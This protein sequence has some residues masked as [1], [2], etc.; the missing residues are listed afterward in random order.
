MFCY[1]IVAGYLVLRRERVVVLI[2]C[3]IY[4][5][6]MRRDFDVVRMLSFDLYCYC[7]IGFTL[8]LKIYKT[9]ALITFILGKIYSHVECYG[10]ICII[11]KSHVYA[12]LLNFIFKLILVLILHKDKIFL[13]YKPRPHYRS[14]TSLC[15]SRSLSRLESILLELVLNTRRLRISIS[16][17][18]HEKF[19]FKSIL[20]CDI[21]EFLLHLF[22]FHPTVRA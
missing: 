7:G 19:H 15:L 5:I 10:L 16:K 4:I 21:I 9:L 20:F 3:Q 18:S 11:T 14:E 6:M 13:R 12:N 22:R 1:D 17:L 2:V 8:L